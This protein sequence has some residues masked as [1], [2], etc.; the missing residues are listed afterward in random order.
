[1]NEIISIAVAIVCLAFFSGAIIYGL[2][3]SK[4][5]GHNRPKSK[6][7]FLRFGILGAMASLIVDT[8]VSA[9]KSSYPDEKYK[10]N[11]QS[12]ENKIANRL[13]S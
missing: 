1:M 8:I 5:Q 3:F 13:N 12:E 2:R 10:K 11:K 4:K 6:D 9:A 7:R